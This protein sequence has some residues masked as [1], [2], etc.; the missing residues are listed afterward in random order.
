MPRK[1]N[2]SGRQIG[3]DRKLAAY[4][5]AGGALVT[6]TAS[7]AM[8]DIVTVPINET[9]GASASQTGSLTVSVGGND[10]VTFSAT[11]DPSTPEADLTVSSFTGSAYAVNSGDP[12]FPAALSIGDT[13]PGSFSSNGF[14]ATKLM[15]SYNTSAAGTFAG[16]SNVYLGVSFPDPS[17]SSQTDFGYIGV[18]VSGVTSSTSPSVTATISSLTYDDTGAP[19]TIGA[20]PEPASLTTLAMGA[21]GV[22]AFLAWRKRRA[23]A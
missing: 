23:T 18:S 5:M 3:L 9:I 2:R 4:A 10:V 7:D 1:T 20:V 6:A 22:G 12:F 21:A 13:V 11:Y 19:I 17:N 8:A 16:L 14:E 15:A